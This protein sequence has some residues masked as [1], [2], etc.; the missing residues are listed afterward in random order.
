[1]KYIKN[2]TRDHDKKYFQIPLADLKALHKKSKN[3]QILD[4]YSIWYANC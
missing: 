4:D 3:Y 2:V 1:M